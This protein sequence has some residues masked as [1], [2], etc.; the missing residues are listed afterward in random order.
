VDEIKELH[1]PSLP[2]KIT[3]YYSI[4]QEMRANEIKI[5]LERASKVFEDSLGVKIDVTIATLDVK[6][7]SGLMD[8]PYGLP[9]LR[10]GTC[11]RSSH[12]FPEARYAA[13]LPGTVGGLVYDGW[14]NLEDSL[15]SGALRKLKEAG[16]QFSQGGEILLDFVGLH[17]L[18]HAYAHAFGINFYVNFFAELI[19]D[20]L[21]YAF[22]RSTSERLDHKVLAVLSANID[23]IRPVHA[24]FK[25]YE[26]FRSSEHPQTEAWYNSVLTLKAAEIF[27]QRGFEF[28]RAVKKNFTEAEGMLKTEAIIQR[29]ETIHPGI[30][31]WSQQIGYL[32]RK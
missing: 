24:S 29:L 2:G 22:L 17:E 30:L 6:D 5:L 13:V 21:S 28:L 27:E 16:L 8:R 18:A 26:S 1:L 31:Q 11:K 3:A 23:G 20:Y 12:R 10:S 9:S 14:M 7:W 4:G 19:A 15:S 25:A 32:A